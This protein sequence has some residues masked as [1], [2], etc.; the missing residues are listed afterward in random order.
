MWQFHTTQKFLIINLQQ[1]ATENEW[2]KYTPYLFANCTVAF[3]ECKRCKQNKNKYW[4]TTFL[5]H[6]FAIIWSLEWW[7]DCLETTYPGTKISTTN[8]YWTS[9]FFCFL[10]FQSGE[11]SVYRV[12]KIILPVLWLWTSPA[13]PPSKSHGDHGNFDG[14]QYPYQVLNQPN[15]YP[16]ALH[17]HHRVECLEIQHL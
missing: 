4:M 17:H 7:N 9:F 11:Y 2:Y 1:A 6:S 8:I 16:S 15:E 14:C 5:A 3:Q 12:I 13:G 10:L